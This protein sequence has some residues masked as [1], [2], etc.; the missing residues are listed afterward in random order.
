MTSIVSCACLW[1]ALAFGGDPG[2]PFQGEESVLATYDLRT[3]MPRWDAGTSWSQTLL[4]PPAVSPHEEVASIEHSLEYADLASF[5]LLDLLTQVLGDELR[6]EGRELLVEGHTLTVLAPPSLHEQVR[7]ILAG[8]EATLAG[9]VALR[10]DV[11]SLAESGGEAGGELAPAGL[12]GEEE[13]SQLVGALVARGAKHESF[14]LALSAGR[15]ARVEAFRRIPFLFDYDAEIAQSMAVLEPVMAETRAGTRLALRGLP[16]AGGLALSTLLLRSDLVGPMGTLPLSGKVLLSAPE[17]GPSE[18]LDGPD[19]IQSPDVLVRGLAFDAFLPEGK[20]L[21]L[22]LEASLG[23]VR[24]R[25]L[26]LLRRQGV[27]ASSYVARPIPRTNRT[28]IALDAGLFRRPRME[29]DATP[30]FDENGAHPSVVASFDGEISGFLLEWMKARFSVWRRFGPWLLIVTDPAWDRDSAAELD[31]LVQALRPETASRT[32]AIDL[33]APGRDGA[34]AV[35]VRLPLLV[36]SSAG[37]VLARGRTAVTDYSS[38]VANGAGMS[39]PWV[40]SIFEGLALA[41]SVQGTTVEA[42]GMAQL[43]DDADGT[44][45]SAYAL[46][47][48]LQVP[49]PRVLRFDERLV[50][51]E[52]PGPL[53]IGGALERG[54][55]GLTLEIAVPAAPR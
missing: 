5:E 29:F 34:S 32:V 24:S 17:G 44:L 54:D 53:R 6:R 38:E 23:K 51:S 36:G 15:T 2:A 21:A 42:K 35:R 31:R 13:A 50:L 47:G 12:L 28:L 7:A 30:W 14:A 8:L 39:D 43:F 25:E 40:S 41:L 37:L 3:V 9:T 52:R 16:V 48:P 19:S 49:Q 26:V 55:T 11:L 18:F 46:L 22:T 20:A 4:V 1:S 27:G 33:R 10:V 45:Q